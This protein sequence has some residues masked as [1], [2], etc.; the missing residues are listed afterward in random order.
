LVT[1]DSAISSDGY[2]LV[3]DFVIHKTSWSPQSIG[4]DRITYDEGA[5][6]WVDLNYGEGGGFNVSISPGWN[7]NTIVWTD[8]L[9]QKGA[10]VVR[11]T[12]ARLR[13]FHLTS[14]GF[15]CMSEAGTPR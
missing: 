1:N 13:L 9:I 3:D 10:G 11:K 15:S 5:Q 14:A 6:R 2:W 4:E 7:G 8:V 12:R